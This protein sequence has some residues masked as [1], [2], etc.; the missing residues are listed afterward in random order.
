MGEFAPMHW[1]AVLVV[2]LIIFG[3]RRLPEIG[4]SL[5][6]AIRDFKKSF[7]ESSADETPKKDE[8]PK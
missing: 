3:P 1:L 5:G 2:A 8:S 6:T 4:R 7:Q